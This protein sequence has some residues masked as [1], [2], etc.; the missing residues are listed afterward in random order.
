M[1]TAAGLPSLLSNAIRRPSGEKSGNSASYRARETCRWPLPSAFIVQIW[2]LPPRLL[3]SAILRPLGEYVG[4][5]S[6]AG[7][8][9][10]LVKLLPSGITE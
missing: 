6:N 2:N 10:S 9:V 3:Q 7:D 8:F 4:H 1:S 5:A